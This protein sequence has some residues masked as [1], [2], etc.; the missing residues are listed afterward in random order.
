MDNK[1]FF[2]PLSRSSIALVGDLY[3]DEFIYGEATKIAEDGLVP[4]VHSVSRS[5]QPAAA[6][7]T[8]LLLAGLGGRIHLLS[9]TGADVPGQ[10]AKNHLMEHGIDCTGLVVDPSFTTPTR[11]RINAGG[12]GHA[13]REMVRVLSEQRQR[14]SAASAA[15]L[16]SRLKR[17]LPRCRA[18]VLMDKDT[19]LIDQELVAFIRT[20]APEAILIG[21]SEKNLPL[22]SR[23]D[24]V[25]ANESETA[26]ALG[27]P[28]YTVDSGDRLRRRLKADLLF[29]SHGADGMSVHQAKGPTRR[30]A[31]ER[32]Q[33]YDR[34]GAG[35]AVVAAIT[36]ALVAGLP[37]DQ[38]AEFANLTA[39]VA[40]A[41]PGLAEITREELVQLQEQRNARLEAH[42]IVSLPELR[43]VVADMKKS[44]RRVVWTNGC[45]DI[46]HVGHILYLEK[47]RSLGDLLVV[48]LNSDAS[49]RSFKGPDRPIVEERQRAKLLS[50]LSC[51]DYVIIFEDASPIKLIAELQPDIYA[52][53][54]DYH[55]GSIN[56]EERRLVEKYG[57]RLALLPG[58]PG[59]STSHL[60]E[61]IIKTY[62]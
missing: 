34:V 62:R 59:M 51:V 24:V 44:G 5:W 30:V 46:M 1:D 13:D 27:E 3:L 33:V 23:F 32:R 16:K 15:L 39:G 36:T 14:P 45:F 58:V 35:E 43:A 18:V 19:G 50:A 52:K 21:D 4:I 29:I 40:I 37:P 7:Y 41:K 42:K 20:I 57:G 55:M 9:R 2:I 10:V 8:A 26:A 60:I 6:G 56:Q 11:L 22:L 31:T 48:G 47:A 25:I 28:A 54:G 49:V 12:P 61:R 53:G 17:I 38:T